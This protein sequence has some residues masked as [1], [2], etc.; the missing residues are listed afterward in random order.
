MTRRRI[1]NL[2]IALAA[3]ASAA[4]VC[5]V[6]AAFAVY[7][8]ARPWVGPAG[9]AAVTAAAFALVALAVAALAARRAEPDAAEEA[10]LVERLIQMAK[11]RPLIALGAAAAILTVII[12]NPAILSTLVSAFVAS[13][14]VKPEK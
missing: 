10:P 8:L 2:A 3:A 7:A 9:A 5:V 14:A 12:R 6:A 4:A 13:S 1:L 11:D